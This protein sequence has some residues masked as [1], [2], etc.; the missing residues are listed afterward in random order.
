MVWSANLPDEVVWYQARTPGFGGFTLWF[1]AV[2][3][4]LGLAVLPTQLAHIPTVLASLAAMLLLMH[5]LETFWLV[6]PAFRGHFT[7]NLADLFALLGLGGL[8]VAGLMRLHR[9]R[10]ATSRAA[11]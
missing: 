8:A 3:V 7:F 5:L 6:T 11:A 9:A 1:A 4:I 10:G 2:A